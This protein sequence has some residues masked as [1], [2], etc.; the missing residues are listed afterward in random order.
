MNNLPGS[1]D[2]LVQLDALKSV[3]QE[4]AAREQ[5]LNTAFHAGTAKENDTF[6]AREQQQAVAA[7]ERMAAAADD[8]AAAKNSLQSRF[9]Q[10]KARIDRAYYRVREKWSS[11]ITAQEE[12]CNDQTQQGL[13]ETEQQRDA[14][15]VQA[16][17]NL[18]NFQQRLAQSNGDFVQLEKTVRRAFGGCGKFRRRLNAPGPAA[19]FPGDGNQLLDEFQRVSEKIKTDLVRFKKIPLPQIFRFI[20]VWLASVV[21]L[22]IA[23]ASPVLRHFHHDVIPTQFAIIALVALAVVLV[24]YFI[25]LRTGGPLAAMIAGEFIR[26]RRLLES[27]PDA[28][29][30]HH[31]LELER[32]EQEFQ[33]A[34]NA[35]NQD[36]KHATK[37]IASRR[38]SHPAELDDQLARLN[39]NNER[40]N[41]AELQ[42]LESAHAESVARLRSESEDQ[43]KQLAEA[44]QARLVALENVSQDGWQ[45]LE[46]E[47]QSRVLPLCETLQTATATA[48]KFFPD[49][50][51][52]ERNGWT[53]PPEFINAAKFARLEVDTDQFIGN[54]PKD[55]LL[56]LPLPPV[57]SLPLL[58]THPHQG[59]LLFETGKDGGGEAVGAINNTILRLFATTP[60]GRL[61]FTIFDPV[62]LGQ[63]FAAMMHLADYEANQINSRIWTQSAQFEEKLAEL[64][65]HMEKIIQMYLRNEYAT[66]T[67]Y[68]AEAGSIAEK[69]HFLVIASF[70]VNFSD[71]AAKRLRNI[72]ANG[73]RCGVF[74]LI[75]WDQRNAA[76]QDFVPDELRR[77]SVGL[78]RT[79]K[80]FE[81]SGWRAAGTKVILDELPS[82]EFTTKLLHQIGDAGKDSN[83]V[84]VPFD[85][86]APAEADFWTDETSLELRVPIGRSGATKLQY[87]AIGRD[88]RQHALIA[89]KTGSGKSTLF[90]IIITN[91]ALHCSPE[92]V[93]FYLVDFKKGVEFKCY[94]NHRLPHAKVVAIESDRAFGL[95]V[96]QRVDDELRRRGDLF[97]KYGAQDVAGY[98]RAT[99]SQSEGE[100]MPRVL[101]MIDEFQ[102]FFTEED[103]VSQNA[104]VLLDRI[105]RQGRAFGIHVI[106]GSQTLGGAY[107]LARATIGQMVIRIALQCNE[108]DAYLI[109]DQDNPAPRLLSRPGEGIYNDTAGSIEGNS[110]FQAVWLPDRMRE[111]YLAKIR[112]RADA[113]PREYPGPIV[114]EGNAPADVR[115]NLPLR[116]ALKNVGETVSPARIW[117]GAP[118]SIKGPTEAIFR[119][120]SA[121]NLLVVGQSDERVLTILVVALVALAAQHSKDGAQFFVFHNVPAEIPQLEFFQRILQ[122][123]P[124]SVTQAG[125][126]NLAEVMVT[127]SAELKRRQE[128]ETAGPEIF[129]FIHDLQNFKKL[130]QEDEFSFSS[131]STEASPAATLLELI[132][133]GPARGIHVILT[134]D[135]YSNLNRFLGRKALGEIEM[136][137]AFQMSAGDSA[138]LIDAPD[139]ATLGLHRAVLFN[140]REGLLETFRPYALPGNDWMEG[141]TK[142]LT[143]DARLKKLV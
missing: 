74:T 52:I 45:K 62:G 140:E 87:L 97:R 142:Q 128:A 92:Q 96:L 122:A 89:G 78:T 67:E 48:E 77:N 19:N 130:R 71:T 108:A 80:G 76:P 85:Q 53:P 95:S 68:N 143:A 63:N 125:N 57:F 105:V 36:W 70:P 88:T 3:V 141:V 54:V 134:C 40:F 10:R 24:V 101:L 127:L 75:Q 91:L 61:A 117:L 115:E 4:F 35:L 93:E 100:P 119:R 94:G 69:Y 37:E 111:D 116:D 18:E 47:W 16:A 132:T 17:T 13:T 82:A 121:A 123:V 1:K 139:A 12:E 133:E 22:G 29:G 112:A 21:L 6:A 38:N 66:I 110:P 7:S 56:A 2:L 11:E 129:M 23:V 42:R 107:T 79:E 137:V 27:S 102:E 90:H 86:I 109:M 46:A 106:L 64:N 26:A 49:W 135:S 43:T 99:A 126:G 81:L 65:E 131:S 30:A 20:P 25:A 73:A 34:K 59:S 32:I 84:E 5:K 138:S 50:P 8:F 39:Q 58:L 98:K 51:T 136:R 33:A 44:R 55:K 83:R 41:K 9:E 72:A 118:N 15:L 113:A 60:P 103:R 124:Q 104:A 31:Q 14:A 120:Q 28:A 114:F